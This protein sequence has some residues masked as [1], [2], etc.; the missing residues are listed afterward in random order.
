MLV[1]ML[2]TAYV[3]MCELGT[4]G[5][6]PKSRRAKS[7]SDLGKNVKALINSPVYRRGQCSQ[8][9]IDVETRWTNSHQHQQV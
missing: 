2:I 6:A 5:Q 4:L 8:S 3:H 1:I 7:H 9:T